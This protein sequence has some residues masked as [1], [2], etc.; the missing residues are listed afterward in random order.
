MI[1]SAKTAPRDGVSSRNGMPEQVPYVWR[2]QERVSTYATR[3]AQRNAQ[4]SS[5]LPALMAGSDE[6]LRLA[7]QSASLRDWLGEA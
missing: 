2:Q 5:R 6:V 4:G 7:V 3:I 1:K